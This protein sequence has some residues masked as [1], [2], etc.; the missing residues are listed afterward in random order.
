MHAPQIPSSPARRADF[1]SISLLILGIS[2]FLF[3]ASLRQT[4][5]FADELSMLGLAWSLLQGTLT[6]RTSAPTSTYISIG[7]AIVFPLFA[8]FY[9]WT[10]KIIYHAVAFAL[11]VLLIVLRSLYLFYWLEPPFPKAKRE[12]WRARGWVALSILLAGYLVWNV[13]LEFCKEIREIR[14]RIGVPWA[15]GLELHGWWHVLTAVATSILMDI[16]REMREVVGGEK[17]E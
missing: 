10:G 8:A 11:A 15:W 7:L 6:M 5:Q 12:S 3:H 4:L 1:M 13:D 2:S 16:V 17:V 9:V 14:E